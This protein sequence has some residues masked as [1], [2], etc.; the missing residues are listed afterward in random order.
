M[1][2]DS[3]NLGPAVAWQIRDVPELIRDSVTE[4]AR[5]E[6]VKVSE[7][8]T[9]LVLEAREANWSLRSST[10][11]A[12]PSN[13]IDRERLRGAVSMVSALGD[14]AQ[15]GVIALANRLVKQELQAIEGPRPTRQPRLQT[16]QT[17][18][19]LP[20]PSRRES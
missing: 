13:K 19:D 15:K 18:P 2:N 4:Q 16:R 17:A 10:T 9:R 1:A 11:F 8:L 3:E 6:G 14:A 7:L 12:N 5:L 20:P